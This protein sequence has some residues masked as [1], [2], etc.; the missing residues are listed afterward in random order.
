MT[1]DYTIKQLEKTF[2]ENAESFHRE[3]KHRKE[4]CGDDYV[5]PNFNISAALHVIC[6]EINQLKKEINYGKTY[7]RFK[8]GDA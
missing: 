2:K 6:K 1:E 3:E 7:Q 8:T 5:T 4:I